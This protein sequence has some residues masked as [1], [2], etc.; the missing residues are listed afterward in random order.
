MSVKIFIDPFC[1]QNDTSFFHI[2]TQEEYIEACRLI[3]KSLENEDSLTIALHN[4]AMNTWFDYL[5]DYSGISISSCDPVQLFADV[6]NISTKELPLE[7][8]QDPE[9]IMHHSLIS[10]AKE[11]PIKVDK[12]VL[13]WILVQILGFVWEF[14]TISQS[15]QINDLI[16]YCLNNQS[17]SN[18]HPTVLALRNRK[19]DNWA[20]SSSYNEFLKWLFQSN[21]KKRAESLVLYRLIFKYPK[22]V[23]IQAL[24]FDGRWTE[25]VELSNLDTVIELINPE[26][27]KSTTIPS[28]YAKIIKDFLYNTI[29]EQS[30]NKIVPY[31]SGFLIEEERVIKKHLNSNLS[32]I[33]YSWSELLHKIEKL[34]V[35]TG[36]TTNFIDFLHR[37]K[38]VEHPG[39]L[40]QDTSWQEVQKWIEKEYI[41][42]YS[43]CSTVNRIDNT[44]DSVTEFEDWLLTNYDEITRKDFFAPYAV[45]EKCSSLAQD[46]PIILIV[47]DGLS[48]EYG[49]ILLSSLAEMGLKYL[50]ANAKITPIPTI[51]SIAKPSVICGQLPSQ[52]KYNDL[53]TKYY[54]KIF[55]DSLNLLASEIVYASSQEKSLVEIVFDPYKAYLYLYNDLDEII[56]KSLSHEKRRE[57]IIHLL[58]NLAESIVSVKEEFESSHQK[59]I[60]IIITSDHGYTEFPDDNVISVSQLLEDDY[61]VKHCRVLYSKKKNIPEIPGL[62]EIDEKYLNWPK[63]TLLVPRGYGCINSK[64]K[65]ATHGGLTPQ[66]VCIPLIVFDPTEKIEYRDIEVAIDGTVRRGRSNNYTNIILI[67]PNPITVEVK[68]ISLRLMTL[69]EAGP[70]TIKP[71]EELVIK[72]ILDATNL[73]QKLFEVTGSLTF[74]IRGVNHTTEVRFSIDTTGAAVVD[75]SFED[76][77]EI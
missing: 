5:K 66:E 30:L 59:S 55:G 21:S 35:T 77:F 72:A 23:I 13:T 48:W 8:K 33:D 14:D 28:G 9:I 75:Q 67:N 7:I 60:A 4:R 61:Q 44:I 58:T 76:D 11:N 29:K 41:P 50:E 46:M 36:A 6:M 54:G 1:T 12:D 42:F 68:D 69:T 73:R 39:N 10:K 57:R 51:T 25:L 43:W 2:D 22:E 17:L 74:S 71:E 34:F 24:Q 53:G 52:P 65:G 62:I 19:I 27:S 64:P 45:H 32:E 49:K 38:P 40:S 37:I 31:I 47:V 63:E 20:S 15:S 26:L 70:F 16:S 56:H 3:D 18:I